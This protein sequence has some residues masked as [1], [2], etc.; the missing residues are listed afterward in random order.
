MQT[1]SR[2][3]IALIT[4]LAGA[5]AMAQTSGGSRRPSAQEIVERLKPAPEEFQSRSFT[6]GTRSLE[7]KGVSVEGRRAPTEAQPSIDLDVNFEYASA[8]LTADARIILDNLGRA[9]TDPALRNSHFLLAGHTDAKGTDEYNQA[10]SMRRAQAVAGYLTKQYNVEANRLKVE[11][12]GRSKLLDPANPLSAI[13]R[14]VQVA[15]LG[16]EK[17]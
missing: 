8:Q 11:G 13:N 12:Y 5:T 10:L 1:S 6:P 15:N 2:I 9:L 4:L 16:E 17:P 14:R 7:A 3:I